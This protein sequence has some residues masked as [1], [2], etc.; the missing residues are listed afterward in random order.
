MLQDLGIG[1]GTFLRI[2]NPIVLEHNQ[3]INVGGSFLLISLMD[4]QDEDSSFSTQIN[5]L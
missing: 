5:P 3:I 1:M 4:L 2:E